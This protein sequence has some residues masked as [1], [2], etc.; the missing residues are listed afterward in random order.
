MSRETYTITIRT[1]QCDYDGCKEEEYSDSGND[2]ATTMWEVIRRAKDLGWTIPKSPR[3]EHLC[4]DHSK[5][6][7]T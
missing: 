5:A 6:K 2:I 1:I 7:A 3:G 4:P